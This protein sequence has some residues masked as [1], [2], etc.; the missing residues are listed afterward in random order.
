MHRDADARSRESCLLGAF[1][2]SFPEN[3]PKETPA[4][5]VLTARLRRGGPPLLRAPELL[6]EAWLW[7]G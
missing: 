5:V 1:I 6:P 7:G 2:P 4:V 3:F